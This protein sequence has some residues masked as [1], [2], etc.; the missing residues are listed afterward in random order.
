MLKEEYGC[1]YVLNSSSEGFWEEF[2]ELA[3]KLKIKVLI[4]C[5]SGELTGQLMQRMPFKSTV[6]FYGAL[7]EQPISEIDPKKFMG[8]N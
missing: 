6:L 8:R 4:E 3:S 5:V 1:A 2:E 7:S